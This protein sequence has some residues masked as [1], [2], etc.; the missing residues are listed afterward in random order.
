MV[1][2]CMCCFLMSPRS[3]VGSL[4]SRKWGKKLM[5][6]H[7]GGEEKKIWKSGMGKQFFLFRANLISSRNFGNDFILG[8]QKQ[9]RRPLMA[10]T[11]AQQGTP[12]RPEPENLTIL[13]GTFSHSVPGKGKKQ[14]RRKCD[15]TRYQFYNSIS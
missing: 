10:I 1:V 9:K 12:P 4:T 14:N 6:S 3:R 2:Y 13:G 8:Q 5:A 7:F 11:S 15:K